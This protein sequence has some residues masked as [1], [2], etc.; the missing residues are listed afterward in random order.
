MTTPRFEDQ[1]RRAQNRA[2][3][4]VALV[5]ALLPRLAEARLDDVPVADLAAEAGISQATFF[6]HFPSKSD[7][8]THFMQ[9]WGLRVGVLARRIRVE[10]AS[11]LRGIEALLA[12]TAEQFVQAPRVMLEIIAHQARMPPDL[13]V[14]PVD[15][16]ERL[17]WLPGEVDVMSL[18]DRGLGGVLP[19]LVADA[20]EAGE[21]PPGTD[22]S[23]LVLAV[24]NVFFGVPLVM[25][26]ARKDLVPVVYQRQLALVWAGARASGGAL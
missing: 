22:E 4:R 14:P 15:L 18:S 21:L 17:L 9:L 7:L 1:P 26:E 20:V 12:S 19:G 13:Q 25:G 23:S 3:T 2:R 8:L 11:A 24:A 16:A 5:E 6:N 10:E